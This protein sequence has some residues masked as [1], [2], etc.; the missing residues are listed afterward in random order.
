VDGRRGRAQLKELGWK[1]KS[2]KGKGTDWKVK[3][4]LSG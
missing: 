2:W 3:S 1:G 4:I